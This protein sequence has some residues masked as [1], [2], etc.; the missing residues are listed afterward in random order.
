MKVSGATPGPNDYN[1]RD[2]KQKWY[3]SYGRAIMGK[4]TRKTMHIPKDKLN[5]PG[6]GNYRMQS[7]FGVYCPNDTQGWTQI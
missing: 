6:P 7:D 3:K 1:P 5:G 4:D 2:K